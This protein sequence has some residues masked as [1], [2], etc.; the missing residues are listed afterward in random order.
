MAGK[1]EAPLV[2]G[3]IR[4]LGGGLVAVRRVVELDDAGLA[5]L[6][7]VEAE[8]CLGVAGSEKHAH[9]QIGSRHGL[10]RL[11][12]HAEQ[13]VDRAPVAGASAGHALLLAGRVRILVDS[14]SGVG[15]LYVHSCTSEKEVDVR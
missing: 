4:L 11:V 3:A 6:L 10:A 2:G 7:R 13:E 9:L 1:G 12:L 15:G 8:E 14:S 5:V